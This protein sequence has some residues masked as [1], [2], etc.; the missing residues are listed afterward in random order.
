MAKYNVRLVGNGQTI[1]VTTTSLSYAFANLKADTEYMVEINAEDRSGNISDTAKVAFT[2][3][4][5][6]VDPEEPGE[7]G[8]PGEAPAWEATKVY[9][10]G[11]VVSYKG[12]LY[13]AK[14][15]TQNN[16]PSESGQY[17]P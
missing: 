6:V 10:G 15:W 14:H 3:L 12:A 16:V 5:D 2:T 9:L 7:P 1:N 13:R 4:A 17:G 8:E 11:E